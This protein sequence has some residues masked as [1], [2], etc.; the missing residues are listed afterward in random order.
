[1]LP[2][3]AD[4]AANV[5]VNQGAASLDALRLQWPTMAELAIQLFPGID[6][7]FA[8]ADVFFYIT[9]FF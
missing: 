9:L 4:A 7:R 3:V 8:H 1:V 2:A 6:A 5:G